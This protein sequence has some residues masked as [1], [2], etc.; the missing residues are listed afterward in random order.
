[1]S[2]PTGVP[3]QPAAYASWLPRVGALIIDSLPTA[4]LFTV[5]TAAFGESEASGSSFSFQLSG[6]PFVVYLVLAVAWFGYNWLHLQGSTGQTVGKRLAGISV[7]TADTGQPLGAGLTFARQLVHIVDALPCG[8]GY[9][10]PIWDREKR[11]FAD[12]ILST[13]VRKA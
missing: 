12:M 7:G 2:E 3:T 11:T 9:L 8:L 6:L 5:L 4:I 1:M 13:R 10:W